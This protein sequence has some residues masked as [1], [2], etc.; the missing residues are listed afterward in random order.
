MAIGSS[1]AALHIHALLPRK[2]WHPACTPPATSTTSSVKPPDGPR[3]NWFTMA[4]RTTGYIRMTVCYVLRAPLELIHQAPNRAPKMLSMKKIKESFQ[5]K[6]EKRTQK[7]D[8][9]VQWALNKKSC[10]MGLMG[11]WAGERQ[12]LLQSG[13]QTIVKNCK[14]RQCHSHIETP[15]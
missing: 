6:K 3:P 10:V 1:A 14:N 11:R 4:Q 2:C 13:E 8:W 12:S 5:K 15:R 9:T 7:I